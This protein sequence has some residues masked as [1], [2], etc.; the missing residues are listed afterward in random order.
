MTRLDNSQR[1]VLDLVRPPAGACAV[2][3]MELLR[4]SSRSPRIGAVTYWCCWS[5]PPVAMVKVVF[6]EDVFTLGPGEPE[7][8]AGK[9]T[10]ACAS[11]PS[12]FDTRPAVAGRWLGVFPVRKSATSARTQTVSRD[13]LGLPRTN[14]QMI[15][16]MCSPHLESVHSHDST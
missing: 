10:R 15:G 6:L 3:L 9:V 4:A 12:Y 8:G 1:G 7:S 14:I 5:A 13:M 11:S 2:H 16:P